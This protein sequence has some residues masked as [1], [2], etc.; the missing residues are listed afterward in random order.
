MNPPADQPDDGALEHILDG[1]AEGVIEVTPSGGV[2][3]RMP[4][5]P[6]SGPG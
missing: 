1:I 4:G 3:F 5:A 6:E 2:I